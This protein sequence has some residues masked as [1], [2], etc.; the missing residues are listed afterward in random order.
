VLFLFGSRISLIQTEIDKITPLRSLKN[1]GF[2]KIAPIVG[3]A[4][5]LALLLRLAE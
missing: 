2:R 3:E 4:T 5:L 1:V